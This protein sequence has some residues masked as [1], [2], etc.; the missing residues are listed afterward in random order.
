MPKVT[1][2]VCI[3]PNGLIGN[4][5]NQM[6]W[7]S[8]Q[9]FFHFVYQT[10]YKPCVFGANTFFNIPTHPLPNRLNVVISSKY[11]NTYIGD[12]IGVHSF[13]TAMAI[14]KKN[15][16][17]MICGGAYLY[18]YCFDNNYIDNFLITRITSKKLIEI[19]KDK[20]NTFFP[21]Y[22]LDSIE[23]NWR[24]TEFNYANHIRFPTISEHGV[25]IRFFN[26]QNIR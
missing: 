26:Y 12:F 18:K 16:H 1:A 9:D 25:D 17:I 22:I 15:K 20:T 5:E 11:Q 2:I 8:R 23:Q 6:P 19:S 14:I 10:K 4:S 3:G 7:Y 13:E 24:K 21:Q